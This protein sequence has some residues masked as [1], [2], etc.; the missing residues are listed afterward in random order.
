MK[1]PLVIISF[2]AIFFT[3]CVSKDYATQILITNKSNE[4]L[5]K[6]EIYAVGSS[7]SKIL[8]FQKAVLNKDEKIESSFLQ[9]L[10]PNSD[11]SYLV[12]IEGKSN[13]REQKFGYFTNGISLDANIS[14][15]IEANTISVK[16]TNRKEGY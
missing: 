7:K 15:S 8:L 5:G 11:G 1:K 6:I 16:T 4:D 3:S 14:I 12:R 9:S 2:C 13:S 10:L